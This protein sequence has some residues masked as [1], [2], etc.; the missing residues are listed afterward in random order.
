MLRAQFNQIISMIPAEGGK[1]MGHDQD[2]K[3]TAV[4]DDRGMHIT[5]RSRAMQVVYNKPFVFA[6]IEALKPPPGAIEYR[7]IEN[8][9]ARSVE[10]ASAAAK[11][12]FNGQDLIFVSPLTSLSRQMT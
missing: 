11:D 8:V 5:T 12:A 9:A 2:F 3:M 6:L 10:A 7:D 1:D 4:K